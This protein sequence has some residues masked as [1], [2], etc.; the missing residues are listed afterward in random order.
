VVAAR[1]HAVFSL[2]TLPDDTKGRR[3]AEDL[4]ARLHALLD[5]ASMT[6]GEAGRALGVNPNALRYAAAT[7][8]VVI[9]WEGARQPTVWTV[10]PPE[11]DPHDARLELA[12]RYLHIYG[13]PHRRPSGSGGDWPTVRPGG[14]RG[15]PRTGKRIVVRWE[16]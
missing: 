3:R 2:G 9:R 16:D 11:I 12:R 10:P 15:A 6:Y 14:V 8:T 13:P 5:G 4:A 1:D 7:G